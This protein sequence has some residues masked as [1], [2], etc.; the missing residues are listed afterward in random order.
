MTKQQDWKRKSDLK[1]IIKNRK[2]TITKDR[3]GNPSG[4]VIL[5][6][7]TIKPYVKKLAN[8]EAQMA[9]NKEAM[10]TKE[11]VDDAAQEVMAD[12]EQNKNDIISIIDNR[13]SKA[14]PKKFLKINKW[15]YVSPAS[16]S[17][18][19][20]PKIKVRVDEEMDKELNIY[21]YYDDKGNA[22][23]AAGS[24]IEWI[25]LIGKKLHLKEIYQRT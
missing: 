10:T 13:F 22:G 12:A 5:D 4:G 17:A 14:F 15:A 21:K 9:A 2:T 19:A 23:C 11:R 16:G 6:E 7:E 18:N 1:R 25:S 8:L 3:H 20:A 24:I